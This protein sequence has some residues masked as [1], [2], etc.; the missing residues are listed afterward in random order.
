MKS[1]KTKI[2]LQDFT[3]YLIGEC[4]RTN[5]TDILILFMFINVIDIHFIHF[6]QN[7]K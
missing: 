3:Y 6:K 1:Y 2:N 5:I 4:S 7:Y